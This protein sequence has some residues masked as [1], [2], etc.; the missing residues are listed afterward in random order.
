VLGKFKD[1]TPNWTITDF[2]GVRSKCYTIRT[3][4]KIIKKLKGISKTLVQKNVEF[5]DYKNCVLNNTQIHRN[6]KAI[7]TKILT[8]YLLSQNKLSYL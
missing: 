8:N 5:E 3:D 4:K 2:I 1:E 6:K 7:R